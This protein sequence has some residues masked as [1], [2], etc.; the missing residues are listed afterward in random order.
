MNELQAAYQEYCEAKAEINE[1]PFDFETWLEIEKSL[2]S[3]ISK[4]ADC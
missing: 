1:E 4:L 3:P 2:S